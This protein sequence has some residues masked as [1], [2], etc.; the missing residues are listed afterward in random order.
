MFQKDQNIK[1]Q[2]YQYTGESLTQ[3]KDSCEIQ[4]LWKNNLPK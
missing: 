3:Y 4:V 2:H 1:I